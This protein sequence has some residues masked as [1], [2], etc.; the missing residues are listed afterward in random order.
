MNEFIP[1][2]FLVFLDGIEVRLGRTPIIYT[3]FMAWRDHIARNVN[4]HASDFEH[5]ADYP[6]WVKHYPL[7]AHVTVV[8]GRAHNLVEVEVMNPTNDVQ[9]VTVRVEVPAGWI[10]DQAEQREHSAN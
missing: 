8:R 2:A 5:F 10:L 3:G 7:P 9:N 6:L 1:V 4:F